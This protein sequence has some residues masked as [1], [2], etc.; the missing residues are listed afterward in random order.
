MPESLSRIKVSRDG[1]DVLLTTDRP[2][3][4]VADFCAG[5]IGL[6]IRE[7][8]PEFDAVMADRWLRR[9]KELKDGQARGT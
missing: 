7:P 5:G 1:G 2:W 4:E 6:K 8:D 9:Q 3:W